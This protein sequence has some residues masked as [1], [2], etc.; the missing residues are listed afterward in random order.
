MDYTEEDLRRR[1]ASLRAR[2]AATSDPREARR[3]SWAITRFSERLACRLEE[4]LPLR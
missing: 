2:L 3:I 4:N 1:I